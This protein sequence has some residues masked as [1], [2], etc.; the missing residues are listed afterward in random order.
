M[1]VPGIGKL[2]LAVFRGNLPYHKYLQFAETFKCYSLQV[3]AR[4]KI[5]IE[6]NRQNPRPK[7]QT[8]TGV[9]P[10]EN[11]LGRR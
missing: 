8:P 1:P 9:D 5:A 4:E 10:L 3:S 7:L 6:E 11:S 2:E